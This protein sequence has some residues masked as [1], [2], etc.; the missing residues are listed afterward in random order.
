MEGG[1]LKR[2]PSLANRLHPLRLR[3]ERPRI[4][5]GA[6]A[7][8]FGGCA[9]PA[10]GGLPRNAVARR[11]QRGTA[12]RT[13]QPAKRRALRA[14]AVRNRA[15]GAGVAPAVRPAAPRAALAGA[16][17]L[18]AHNPEGAE[19]QLWRAVPRRA[20]DARRHAQRRLRRRLPHRADK[21]RPDCPARQTPTPNRARVHGYADGGRDRPA[22]SAGWRHC[23]TDWA[24]R[25][26]VRARRDARPPAGDHPA[27]N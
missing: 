7:H 5:G 1:T 15:D 26:G 9:S 12:H 11:R 27:P 4:H 24:G 22:R 6:A 16:G 14:T 23:H 21:P 19:R 18:R 25:R 3:R 17:D 2:P 13:R 10:C 20:P 8:V